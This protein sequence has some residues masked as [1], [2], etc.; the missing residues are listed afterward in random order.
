MVKLLLQGRRLAGGLLPCLCREHILQGSR[1]GRKRLVHGNDRISIFKAS[2]VRHLADHGVGDGKL[3]HLSV[4]NLAQ[5]IAPGRREEVPGIHIVLDF[6]AQL[7]SKGHLADR[8]RQAALLQ[9]ISGNNPSRFDIIQELSVALHGPGVVRELIAILW[10]AHHHQLAAGLFELRGDD[11]CRAVHIHGKGYQGGRHINLPLL[12]VKCAGHAVLSA[13]GGKAKAHLGAVGAEKCRKRLAPAGGI[14]AHSA[15]IL[16][17]GK[18]DLPVIPACG[19]DLGDGG[20]HRVHR[21]VVGAPAGE[22]G[23]KAVAHHGHCVRVSGE[24]RKLGHHGLGLRELILPAVGHE[25]RACADGSVK[26]LH[27]PL[28]GTAV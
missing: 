25:D 8:L 15:E 5:D 19:R 27:Q 26:P 2:A 24:H 17:E 4:G 3:A 7:I 21:P 16:L 23:V 10:K 28:L 18:A 12:R 11:I 13:D 9:R 6:H 20:H 14:R 1:P 22:I